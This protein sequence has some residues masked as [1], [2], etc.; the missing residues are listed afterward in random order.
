MNM[1]RICGSVACVI[2]LSL[3]ARAEGL[4]EQLAVLDF[5]PVNTTQDVASIYSDYLRAHLV[6][7]DVVLV[8]KE[9]IERVLGEIA[10]QQTGVTSQNDAIQI[11]KM[12]NVRKMIFGKITKVKKGYVVSAS[13]VAVETNVIE[14]AEVTE[15]SS[16]EEFRA[17][18]ETLA[19]GLIGE[20]KTHLN[21]DDRYYRT[22]FEAS[23]YAG[24]FAP[25]NYSL[26]STHGGGAYYGAGFWYWKRQTGLMLQ[27]G[28]YN[29]KNP[30]TL[31]HRLIK[32]LGRSYTT[33]VP[34]EQNVVVQPVFINLAY[35]VRDF[36]FGAGAGCLAVKVAELYLL[37]GAQERA[38]T[39]NLF[40]AS[41]VFAG[42]RI[43]KEFGIS[44]AYSFAITGDDV[45]YV[46]D[47]GGVSGALTY[48]FSF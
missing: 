38:T 12:L 34:R 10:F 14:R 40:Y 26:G 9:N 48:T 37:N 45:Y 8:D 13:M 24:L 36:R 30:F 11:G 16:L 21:S 5:A 19:G 7:R 1:R 46:K 44:A 23:P 27:Y 18:A 41:Q 25:V 39:S 42:L 31:S 28:M 4:K 32:D 47:F 2:F 15:V 33:I 3:A 35:R 20:K 6:K 22:R 43:F 17:S 29:S